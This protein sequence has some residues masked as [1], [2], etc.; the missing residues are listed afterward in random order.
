[1]IGATEGTIR[2]DEKPG[3]RIPVENGQLLL[4]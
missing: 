3:S 1:M 2:M 4:N